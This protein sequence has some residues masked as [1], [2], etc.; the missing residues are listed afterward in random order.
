MKPKTAKTIAVIIKI[1]I[2]FIG[3]L[4]FGLLKELRVGALWVCII[5]VGILWAWLYK[6]ENL[7]L[8][9]KAE[10]IKDFKSWWEWGKY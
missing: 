4:I 1:F 6:W 9:S 8:K 2:I 7:W 3:S 10:L 5:M